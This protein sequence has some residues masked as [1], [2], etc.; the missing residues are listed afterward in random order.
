MVLEI[1]YLL[2]HPLKFTCY[3]KAQGLSNFGDEEN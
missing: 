3:W 2:H 1:F